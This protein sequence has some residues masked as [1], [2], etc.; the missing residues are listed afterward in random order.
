MA[1]I[2][3][4]LRDHCQFRAVAVCFRARAGSRRCRNAPAV[5]ISS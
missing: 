1:A 3:E 4:P 5:R 2:V